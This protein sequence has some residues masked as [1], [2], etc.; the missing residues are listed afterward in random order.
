MACAGAAGWL[1]GAIDPVGVAALSCGAAVLL[2]LFLGGWRL[3]KRCLVLADIERQLA[4]IE[5]RVPDGPDLRTVSASDAIGHGWNALLDERNLR[6]ALQA[7][8]KSVAGRLGSGGAAGG[9]VLNS[10][11][12]GIAVTDLDGRLTVLNQ[13]LSTFLGETDS[14]QMHCQS[15]D[16]LLAAI[17]GDQP[18]VELG[19][20]S[21]SLRPV[22]IDVPRLSDGTQHV[23]RFCRRP[24]RNGAKEVVGH[25][26]TVRDVTQQNLAEQMRDSFVS[27]A[28]HELR[29][30]LANIRAYAE[31]LAIADGIDVEKQKEFCN[32][33]LTE[34][35]RL[36]RFVD[37]LLDVTRLQ[38]GS[39]TLE[40]RSTDLER[41][42]LDVCG[43]INGQVE[44]KRIDFKTEMPAKLPE[45]IVDKDKLSAS[46]MNL[47]GNAVKYSPDGGQVCFRV[48]CPSPSEKKGQRISFVVE[49]TGF[50]IAPDELSRVFEK[51]FR[52]DDDRVRDVVGSGLGLAFVQEV[53]RLHGGEVKVHSELDKGS[54]FTLTIPLAGETP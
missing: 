26:W 46:L 19:D 33:I 24:H 37:E 16:E 51:F 32:T 54:R 12:E 52:S 20:L 4:A 28:S 14:S 42:L 29:T 7:L 25:V 39:L 41:L 36:G 11:S 45:A 44:Q 53:A 49:D 40:R 47:L 21:G 8:E 38:A 35:T 5:G 48:E 22:S 6:D 15:I 1:S 23:M 13:T 50:G 9:D 3:Q 10:L 27:T 34:A 43:K 30:P 18:T 17:A 2:L 31:T